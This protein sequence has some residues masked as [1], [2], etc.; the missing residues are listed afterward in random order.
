MI[1]ENNTYHIQGLCFG[2]GHYR[3]KADEG[4]GGT[5]VLNFSVQSWKYCKPK[6]I[7]DIKGDT[8]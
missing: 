1:I 5:E 4:L 3:G 2:P 6:E 7:I 8:K